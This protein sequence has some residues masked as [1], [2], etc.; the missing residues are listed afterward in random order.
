M[1][2]E[3][4]KVILLSLDDDAEVMVECSPTPDEYR[5]EY[6]GGVRVVDKELV[7]MVGVSAL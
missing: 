5:T 6:C 3:E 2:V 7:V 4:L 1:T